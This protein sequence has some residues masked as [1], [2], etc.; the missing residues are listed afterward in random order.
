MENNTLVIERVKKD[1]EGLYECKASN[2][3]GQDS[4]SAF[5]KIQGELQAKVKHR[6]CAGLMR[7]FCSAKDSGYISNPSVHLTPRFWREIQHRSHHFGLHRSSSYPL[8]A[9]S[10]PLHSEAEKSKRAS[11]LCR[12]SA[13]GP[14]VSVAP[15]FRAEVESVWMFGTES[16]KSAKRSSE[17]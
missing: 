12:G 1:D 7:T 15:A 5:I 2:D 16:R 14:S 11:I 4:T 17:I 8:L 9:S 13:F 6:Y 3:M 10:D